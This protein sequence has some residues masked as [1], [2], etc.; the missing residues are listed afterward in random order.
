MI[1]TVTLNPSIDQHWIVDDLVKDDTNRARKVI[2]TPGG[3]GINVSKVIRELGGKTHAYALLGGPTGLYLAQLARGLDFPVSAVP[4]AGLTRTNIVITDVKDKTQTRVSARGPRVSSGEMARMVRTLV[5]CRGRKT[6]WAFGG[7]LP[8]GLPDATYRD[9]IFKLQKC[10]MLCVLDTDDRALKI[11]LEALPFMIKP[12]EH[13][14][15]RLCGKRLAGIRAYEVEARKIV[16]RGL[17]IA[18]VSLGARG[19]LFVTDKESFHVPSIPVRV[20]SKVGAGDSLI[21]GFLWGL[22]RKLPIQQAAKIGIA[23]S[24]SAVMREAPR[25]CL[26]R[27]IPGIVRRLRVIPL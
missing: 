9:M 5:H 20:R 18:I 1:G 14:M 23:A 26:K 11:G 25:L 12:N 24:T 3:K 22:H 8:Q 10:G 7:S 15:Q 13:E 27:D 4:I 16:R 2:S 21:G 19:A 17:K 6:Y